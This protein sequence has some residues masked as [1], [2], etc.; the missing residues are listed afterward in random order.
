MTVLPAIF[1]A[2]L[3]GQAT[4]PAQIDA[5]TALLESAKLGE[6]AR[7][8]ELLARGAHVN[9]AD[10]RGFTPL[11]WASASGSVDMVRQLLDG[12]AAVDRRASDGTT[13]LML[14]SAMGL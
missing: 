6:L 14:A 3:L 11:M 10:W 12:G 5:D 13:A 1:I 7:T 9:T 4:A 8:K 2:L